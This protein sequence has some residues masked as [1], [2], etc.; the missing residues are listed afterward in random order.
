MEDYPRDL[1]ELEARFSIEIAC[2]KYLAQLRWPDGFRCPHCSGGKAWP[3]CGVLWSAWFAVHSLQWRREP[4]FRI[5]VRLLF[6]F[7]G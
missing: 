3:V 6:A 5:L 1:L 2:R 4:S 7:S